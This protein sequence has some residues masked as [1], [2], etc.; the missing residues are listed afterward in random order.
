MAITEPQSREEI[1]AA[2]TDIREQG[3]SFWTEFEPG[4]FAAPIGTAWSPADNIRHLIKSTMPV[5]KALKLPGL[6][7]RT[8]FGPV[9]GGSSSYSELVE[10]YRAILA[11]GANAGKF[12]PRTIAVPDDMDS[13]QRKLI[14]VCRESVSELR[15]AAERWSESDLDRYRLPHPLLGKITL[16]E[17]LFFTIYHFSHHRENVVRRMRTADNAAKS[18]GN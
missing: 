5:T 18:A 8:L 10:R 3:L 4:Q 11:D 16:R 6:V 2:L 14:D 15:R 1:L 12:A 7:L 13:Y 17:M 9:K